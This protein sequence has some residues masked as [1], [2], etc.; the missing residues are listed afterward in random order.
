[1]LALVDIPSPR[2]L[3][4]FLVNMDISR[5]P[6]ISIVMTAVDN[7]EHRRGN[8]QTLYRHHE[9]LHDKSE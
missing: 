4:E 6:L 9:A 7:I 1:M 2:E 3:T 5:M 8:H